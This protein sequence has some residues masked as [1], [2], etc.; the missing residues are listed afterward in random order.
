M[1]A[2]VKS[3]FRSTCSHDVTYT[4]QVED[5]KK[6]VIKANAQARASYLGTKK[7]RASGLAKLE[8]VSAESARRRKWLLQGPATN[9]GCTEIRSP[10]TKSADTTESREVK[11]VSEAFASPMHD[12]K[13]GRRDDLTG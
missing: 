12:A 9:S 2:L 5:A 7:E 3:A 8:E 10:E 6:L 11:P 4:Y 1:S 13:I